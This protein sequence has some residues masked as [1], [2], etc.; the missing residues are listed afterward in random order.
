VRKIGQ[1]RCVLERSLD[2]GK[3]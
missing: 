1:G 2:I 3:V